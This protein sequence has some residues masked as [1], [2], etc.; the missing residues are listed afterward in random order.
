MPFSMPGQTYTDADASEPS[1][2][3]MVPG[4]GGVVSGLDNWYDLQN[5]EVNY[6]PQPL[7]NQLVPVG[8]V[9][10]V[11][12]FFTI[13]AIES[14]FDEVAH[15]LGA[16][17]LDLRLDFLKGR[18]RNAGANAHEVNDDGSPGA[19]L[20]GPQQVTVDGGRRLANVLKI[21]AGQANYASSLKGP[22]VAQGI[23]VAG[24][25][26][27]R[28]P[29]FAACVADVEGLDSGALRVKKLTVCADVGVAINPEGIRSQIEGSLLWGLS[30]ATY[31]QATLQ[32]G[33]LLESNF[34]AYKWQ[35]NGSLPELDIHIVENGVH[36]TGIGENTLSLVAPAICNAIYNLTEKR[37][38]S[39]P[40]R[41]HIQLV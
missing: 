22:N 39:L 15:Q 28:N 19:I 38:R 12:N 7:M 41:N 5:L 25:E 16:D 24:A 40:L 13:F 6:Y 21:A 11:G 31:E 8:F 14:F 3:E 2:V 36:P 37:I 4:A 27:R 23:A 26:N 34:D 29:T 10:S 33:R 32:K 1:K 35:R 20:R 18:G 17:P 9:R 30:S